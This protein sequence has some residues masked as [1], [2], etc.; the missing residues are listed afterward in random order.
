MI[1]DNI[2]NAS[3]YYG[4]GE[5]FKRALEYMAKNM[6][7]ISET[8]VLDDEVKIN[9]SSYT[10]KKPDECIKLIAKIKL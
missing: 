3:K 2:K 6:D 8:V 10:T 9:Y 5:G 1:V 7:T 4:L